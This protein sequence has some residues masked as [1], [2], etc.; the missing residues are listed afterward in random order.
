MHENKLTNSHKYAHITLRSII[1]G[2]ENVITMKDLRSQLLAEEAMVDN[3]H[4]T[5]F[6]SAMVAQNNGSSS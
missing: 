5:P 3:V 4:I 6:L 1:R 2:H